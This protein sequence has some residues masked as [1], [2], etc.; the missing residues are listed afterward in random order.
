MELTNKKSILDLI[1]DDLHGQIELEI[2]QE[3]DS[4]NRYL[5]EKTPSDK[6][7]VCIA[8]S[9]LKGRGRHGNNWHS[10]AGNNI[11][12]SI[13]QCIKTDISE[14]SGLSLVIGITLAEILQNHCLDKI[15][16]KWPNDLLVNNKKLS[17]IL[18]ELKRLDEGYCQ[19]VTG[20]GINLEMSDEQAALISQPCIS[21]DNCQPTK[22]LNKGEIIAEILNHLLPSM[23]SF[24]KNGFEAFH[25]KWN[26]L[27][28]WFNK[29]VCLM[30]GDKTIT[31][32]HKG[33]DCAGSLLLEQ[34]G[35]ITTW[36]SGEISL[37][38][39]KG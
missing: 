33:V 4:T 20:I 10:P 16:V 27:D 13:S 24:V 6:T 34:D 22:E 11:Y 26:T 25:Q 8:N 18:I 37:R 3:L 29:P 38:G 30:L 31:G 15:G 12:L 7:Q 35:K 5:L 2:H 17:G 1:N 32:I 23:R 39:V 21:L 14:L 9:Q 36:H 28:I 19:I